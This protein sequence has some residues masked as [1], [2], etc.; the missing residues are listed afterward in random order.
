M[1]GLMNPEHFSSAAGK[2]S[3]LYG[4][5]EAGQAQGEGSGYMDVESCG[6]MTPVE[7]WN[8]KELGVFA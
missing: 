4:I 7:E 6:S 3:L 2:R 1:H 8:W 5:S